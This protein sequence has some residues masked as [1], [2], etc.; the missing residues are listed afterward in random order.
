[1]WESFPSEMDQTFQ[2]ITSL[3]HS[4]Q[5][6][7]EIENLFIKIKSLKI[8]W[9]KT[10]HFHQNNLEKNFNCETKFFFAS[11]KYFQFFQTR[12]IVKA[13]SSKKKMKKLNK[14]NKTREL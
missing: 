3:F 1:M 7:T 2:K 4:S 9:T 11:L 6:P 10:K 13:V 5:I 8:S 14:K 12:K